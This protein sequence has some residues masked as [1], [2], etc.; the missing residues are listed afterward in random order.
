MNPGNV[1]LIS[2]T[3]VV[4]QWSP[5]LQWNVQCDTF[6]GNPFDIEATAEFMHD[7]SGATLSTPMYYSGDNGWSFRFTGTKTGLWNFI[8]RSALKQL[9]GLSGQV[10][11]EKNQNPLATGFIAHDKNKWTWQASIRM[12]WWAVWA[13]DRILQASLSPS[14]AK[15]SWMDSEHGWWQ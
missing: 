12:W 10:R 14:S 3:P 8:S 4:T 11:V 13:A 6:D 2:E 15:T 9:D 7:D 1:V 5:F